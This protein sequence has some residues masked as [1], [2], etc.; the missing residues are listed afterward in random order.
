MYK[1]IHVKSLLKAHSPQFGRQKCQIFKQI[2]PKIE[3]LIKAHPQI[4]NKFGPNVMQNHL[5]FVISGECLVVCL[6]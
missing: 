2:S 3:P 5:E 6:Q 4:L 1:I